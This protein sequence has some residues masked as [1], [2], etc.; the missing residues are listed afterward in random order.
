[1]SSNNTKSN[2]Y[3]TRGGKVYNG[4]G[5]KFWKR[6]NTNNSPKPSPKCFTNEEIDTEE[7]SPS[8]YKAWNLYFPEESKVNYL[9]LANTICGLFKDL[10]RILLHIRKYNFLKVTF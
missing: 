10:S 7:N 3:Y 5:K 8:P 6:K 2:N 4:N 1:M 9:I